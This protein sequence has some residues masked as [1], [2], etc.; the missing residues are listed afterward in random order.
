MP[1]H[2]RENLVSL[3]SIVI[4]EVEL[5]LH[6]LTNGFVALGLMAGLL[7]GCGSQEA[8]SSVKPPAPPASPGKSD[9]LSPSLDEQIL[10]K[11]SHFDPKR[12]INTKLLKAATLYF[13]KNKSQFANQKALTIIDFSIHSSK[14]R[15]YLM[16]VATGEVWNTYTAHGAG[17]DPGSFDDSSGFAEVFS[18]TPQSNATSIGPYMTDVTYQGKH[19][20]SLRLKGLAS[21]NSNAYSRAIVIHGASYVLDEARKQGRSQGCPALPMEYHEKVIDLIKGGSLI[22]AG[23][24]AK[25]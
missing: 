6:K 22:Y 16:N 19:G 21:T 18:N 7:S 25:L 12:L 20:Y 2:K 3:K 9:L 4:Q 10:S 14:K 8:F 17:S 15:F 13:H 1:P 5:M 24:S 23:A 11:Y